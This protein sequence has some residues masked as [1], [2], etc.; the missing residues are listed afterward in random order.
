[1]GNSLR[2]SNSSHAVALGLVLWFGG[3][4]SALADPP[5]G[6]DIGGTPGS[7]PQESFLS[8]LKQ[9]FKQDFDHDVVRGH[10]DVGSAPDAH[11]YYCLVDA[12]TGKPQPS[13]VAGEPVHRADGMT[14]IKAS[15]T[16]LYSCVSAEQQGIL[17]TSGYVLN[18]RAGGTI[19]TGAPVSP[20]PLAQ[21]R[22]ALPTVPETAP[23]NIEVAGVKLGMS[24][25]EVRAVLKSKKLLDYFESREI[26][27]PIDSASGAPR[28][29]TGGHFVNVIA[30]WTRADGGGNTAADEESY[31]VM[32]TPVPGKERAMAITHSAAYAPANAVREM[33]LEQALATKYG[34]SPASNDFPGSATW[35]VQSNGSV[36]VGDACNRRRIFGGLGGRDAGIATRQNLAR[37]TTPDEFRFQVEHCG[38]A[39]VTEDHSTANSTAPR[40]ERIVTRFT[41]TAYSPSIGF[42]GATAA[43]LIEGAGEAAGNTNVPRVKQQPAPDL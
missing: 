11:R 26:L 6:S 24:P 18:G 31:E 14:G 32:F 13:G 36:E 35:R 7:V 3:G 43:R 4:I 27:T 30:A 8:S 1:M 17:V 38:V 25:D 40:A 39:I 2:I 12:K 28:P 21:T 41:V 5:A 19:T 9:A 15:A 34:G 10:F 23:E 37:K 22:A 42:A 16:S 29:T 20:P 33:T